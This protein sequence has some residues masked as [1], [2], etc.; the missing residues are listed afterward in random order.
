MT[1]RGATCGICGRRGRWGWAF[2]LPTLAFLGLFSVYPVVNA[3]YLS[4]F[5]K[6]LLSRAPPRFIGFENYAHLFR[7]P[8]F[9]NSL[10]ATAIFAGGAF[11][12]LVGLSLLLALLISSRRRFQHFL[13]LAFFSP[14]VVSTVVAASI[15]LLIFEPR[16]IANQLV[17]ALSGTPGVDHRW[18]VAPG[19]LQLATMLVYVWKYVGYF[20]IIFIAGIS[21]IPRSLVEAA[22]VDGASVWQTFWKITFPL[23]KP[24]TLLVS[25]IAMI[26]CLRTFSTQYLFSQAGSPRGPIDVITLNVYHTAI[27]RFQI[28]RASALSIILFAIMLFLSWLQFR[29]ARSEEVSYE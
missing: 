9:W 2:V 16:G 10:A 8:T 22:R 23:L 28:G 13:Q 12:M 25:V 24:T 29:V 15:W 17:N 1:R 26:Q 3:F 18:L 21:S 4:F 27:E 5:H 11:A 14:A 20:T 19:M 6:H 7:S